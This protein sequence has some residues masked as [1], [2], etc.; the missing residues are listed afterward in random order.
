MA[1]L[2]RNELEQRALRE[3]SR[4]QL[5]RATQTYIEILRMEPRDRR[6][7]QKLAEL[8]LKGGRRRDAER[9]YRQLYKAY[10]HDGNHR[11]LVAVLLKVQQLAP[12]D[13]EMRG[14][15]GESY[16][17]LGRASEAKPLLEDAWRSLMRQDIEMALGFADM[18]LGL[19]PSDIP[20]LTEIAEGL[21]SLNMNLRAFGY[22]EKGIRLYRDRG[23]VE[24]MGRLA[25]RALELKPD[26]PDLLRAAAEASLSVDDAATALQ[27]LQPAFANNPNDP[28]VLDLMARC[29]EHAGDLPKARRVLMELARVQRASSKPGDW[30]SALERADK[31]GEPGLSAELEQAQAALALAELRLH[32]LPS[33]APEGEAKGR[34][35]VQADVFVRYGFVDR[36]ASTLDAARQELPE[37]LA[38]LAWRA[39]VAAIQE[40]KPLAIR[41][42]KLFLASVT[43]DEAMRAADRL[44][45]LGAQVDLPDPAAHSTDEDE[46][47]DDEEYIDDPPTD[48]GDVLEDELDP[49][50]SAPDPFADDLDPFAQAIKSRG[51]QTVDVDASLDASMDADPFAGLDLDDDEDEGQDSVA[52]AIEEARGL[53]GMGEFSEAL[54]TL[55]GL[56]GLEAATLRARCQRELGDSSGALSALRDILDEADEGEPHW[57]E[58]LFELADLAGR[59]QKPKLALRT[60]KRVHDKDPTWRSKDV[61]AR[62]RLLRKRLQK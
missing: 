43:G 34:P 60:L 24:E 54:S 50:S 16:R 26:E 61:A 2:D 17:N 45:S 13:F 11:A 38:L 7:R 49:F 40:D 37:D 53:I 62:V 12:E 8:Y 35:C 58:A 30:L 39:E 28:V 32:Q 56:A 41:L 29:F 31:A 46:L 55:S 25:V 33:A 1:D 44:R 10:R 42:G 14:R 15:L 57:M 4:D 48:A 5:D 18:R 36:A 22:Y 3:L 59:G 21:V 19:D 52:D 27:H 20:F 23:Q 9:Q 47:I 51:M 6:I